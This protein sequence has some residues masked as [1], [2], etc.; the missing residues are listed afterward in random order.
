MDTVRIK[1]IKVH[2]IMNLMLALKTFR[3]SHPKNIIAGDLN[4]DS[5]RNKFMEISELM[6]KNVFATMWLSETKIDTI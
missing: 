1:W 4:I 2:M 3:I 6:C 5:V